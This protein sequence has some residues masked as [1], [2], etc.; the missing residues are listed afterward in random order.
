MGD[1]G[2]V[3]RPGLGSGSGGTGG[4]GRVAKP[5]LGRGFGEIGGDGRVVEP[6]LGSEIGEVGG[7]GSA[8]ARCGA[9]SDKYGSAVSKSGEVRAEAEGGLED[10]TDWASAWRT[11]GE[12]CT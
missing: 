7:E 2:R 6:G 9:R 3:A 10:R 12:G 5:G 4:E 8:G 1:E 11:S